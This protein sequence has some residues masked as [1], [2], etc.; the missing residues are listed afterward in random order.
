MGQTE[1]IATLSVRARFTQLVALTLLAFDS[2][3]EILPLE[4]NEGVAR[5]TERATRAV[6]AFDDSAESR[7]SL[8]AEGTAMPIIL[9]AREEI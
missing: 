3:G 6:V 4:V 2:Q 5:I 7:E 1:R 8:R 9:N